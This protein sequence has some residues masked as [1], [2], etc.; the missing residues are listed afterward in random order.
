MSSIEQYEKLKE[1]KREVN[2]ELFMSV[3]TIFVGM[4]IP[5]LVIGGFLT[6]LFDVS[7]MSV[8]GGKI[9]IAMCFITSTTLTALF[10]KFV[11]D[12][13]KL[14]DKFNSEHKKI[15]QKIEKMK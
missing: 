2:Y 12:G 8:I 1:R 11:I 6:T 10:L 14:Y 4:L 9:I 3:L 15:N 13:N 7:S 5:I